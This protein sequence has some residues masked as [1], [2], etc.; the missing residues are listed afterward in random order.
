MKR[1]MK[2][3]SSKC[4]VRH[5]ILLER[6]KRHAKSTQVTNWGFGVQIGGVAVA[7]NAELTV[8][9]RFE[10]KVEIIGGS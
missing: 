6:C 4:E 9:P 2:R 1:L 8:P 7:G 5:L 3:R 10:K